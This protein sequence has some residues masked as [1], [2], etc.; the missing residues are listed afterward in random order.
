M[1][2]HSS[3]RWLIS[4]DLRTSSIM[5]SDQYCDQ[6]TDLTFESMNIPGLERIS[7][8]SCYNVTYDIIRAVLRGCPLL[9]EISLAYC[10]H[11]GMTDA[12]PLELGLWCPQLRSISLEGCIWLTDVGVSSLS[13]GCPLLQSVD[14]VIVTL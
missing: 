7:L 8:D 6:I 9:V 3:M 2:S 5:M 14:L 11:R 10:N 13:R 12:I 4:R 1:H